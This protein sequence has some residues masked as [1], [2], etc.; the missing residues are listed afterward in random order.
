MNYIDEIFLRADIQQIRGF[1]AH[2]TE[3][4]VMPGTFK[5]RIETV[6]KKLQSRMKKEFPEMDEYEEIMNLVYDYVSATEDVY[7]EIGLQIGGILS[8]QAYQ[9]YTA[10]LKKT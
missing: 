5:E 1:L 7:M 6:E 9:N 3:S 2:G 4:M 8:S 10:S